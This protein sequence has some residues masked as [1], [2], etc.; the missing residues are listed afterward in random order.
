MKNNTGVNCIIHKTTK[1]GE[2]VTFGNNVTIYPH[3]TIEDNVHIWDNCVIGRIPMGVKSII[4]KI[5]TPENTIIRC[6]SIIGC[7][8]VIYS[9]AVI[10]SDNIVG[11]NSVIRE[12]VIFEDDVIIGFN[13]TISY[14]VSIGRGTRVL[15]QSAVSAFSVIGEDNFI[16]IG[17]TS[18]SDKYFK[19]KG[20]SANSNKGP[21][22]GNNNNIG[23]HVT[24]I[25]DIE[26][27]DFN[28]IGAHALLTKSIGSNGVYYG[29]PAKF[30]KKR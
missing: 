24:L 26:I 15:Q 12:N 1:I 29:V 27:G 2:N 3:V 22:I 11:D 7:G 17:F 16:S 5:S 18:V 20:F 30:V 25:S 9:G 28:V 10:G 6:N 14:N 19:D 4:R 23:P 8:C 21:K 13:T